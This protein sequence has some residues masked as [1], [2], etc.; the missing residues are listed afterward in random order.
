MSFNGDD[1]LRCV[2]RNR[3]RTLRDRSLGQLAGDLAA[4]LRK[5]ED[6][7]AARIAELLTPI[8]DDEFRACCRI[9]KFEQGTLCISVDPPEQV[10]PMRRKWVYDLR[11][12]LRRVM[13]GPSLTHVAFEPGT[14]GRRV[15]AVEEVL[16]EPRP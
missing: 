2:Q 14:A 11:D 1:R 10:F 8:V 9:A 15:P 6:D 7:S 16:S 12:A 4:D 13:R 3:F 5:L